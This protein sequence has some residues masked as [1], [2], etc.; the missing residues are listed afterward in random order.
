MDNKK[1]LVLNNQL[2]EIEK[3]PVLLEEVCS[4]WQLPVSVEASLNLVLEE[5]VVN[6]IQYAYPEGE[7]GT[8]TI[9]VEWKAEENILQFTLS[10]GGKPFDPTAVPDADTSLSVEERPIGGLG[11]FL[12]RQMMDCVEYRYY[13]NRNTLVM[14]KRITTEG[15]QA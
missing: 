9:E 12:S 1:T 2:E 8:L 10:D 15:K 6:V 14:Q 4:Q 3:L 11:I 13:N 5:A 7:E